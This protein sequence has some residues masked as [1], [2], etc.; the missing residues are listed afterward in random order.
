MVQGR[1]RLDETDDILIFFLFLNSN[2]LLFRILLSLALYILNKL[3]KI[4]IQ[5]V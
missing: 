1:I 2:L 5:V 3:D 4:C